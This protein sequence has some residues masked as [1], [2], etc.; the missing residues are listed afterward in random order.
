MN[1][2]IATQKA[3]EYFQ[4]LKRMFDAIAKKQ[5][6][7]G[8]YDFYM[9]AGNR[10]NKYLRSNEK[11]YLAA[12]FVK[13]EPKDWTLFD[14]PGEDSLAKY[15]V[16]SYIQMRKDEGALGEG[17]EAILRNQITEFQSIQPQTE[18]L[19]DLPGKP[20]DE[21][22]LQEIDNKRAVTNEYADIID[23]NQ[24]TSNYLK[25]IQ[26]YVPRANQYA[27]WHKLIGSSQESKWIQKDFPVPYDG[28]NFIINENIRAQLTCFKMTPTGQQEIQKK[29]EELEQ[30]YQK[31]SK[32]SS[33][34][35][36]T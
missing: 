21:K 16:E 6:E 29:K 28:K 32:E 25:F 14:A 10:M 26:K 23:E 18:N 12:L 9:E 31:F 30:K 3:Q 7:R 19:Q 36:L 17:E 15:I 35:P 27:I 2:A 20:I 1:E 5:R 4:R 11:V 24:R 13:G 8:S 33:P 34:L 22:Y